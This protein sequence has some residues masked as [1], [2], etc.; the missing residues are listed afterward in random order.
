MVM[1]LFVLI[2]VFSTI[3]PKI[4]DNFI[5][6][7]VYFV[8]VYLTM[9]QYKTSIQSFYANKWIVLSFGIVIYIVLAYGEFRGNALA[10]QYIDDFKSVPNLLISLCV[11]YFFIR[12][13]IGKSKC[14]NWFAGSAFAVYIVHQTPNFYEILWNEIFKVP[15]WIGSD[16]LVLYLFTFVLLTYIL[17]VSIDQ[18]RKKYFEPIWT[19]SR[20]FVLLNKELYGQYKVISTEKKGNKE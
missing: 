19:R 15:S 20:V 11:F 18:V 2:S 5:C 4:W 1:I 6:S 13:D 12:V 10:I 3:T 17:I 8:F 9:R 7:F 14:I 16:L